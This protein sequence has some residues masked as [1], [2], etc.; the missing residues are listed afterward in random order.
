MGR[1][2]QELVRLEEHARQFIARQ[3]G[4]VGELFA[5]EDEVRLEDFLSTIKQADG[6]QLIVSMSDKR[7]IKDKHNREKGL[8]R[9]Q[10]HIQSGKN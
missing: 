3:E 8:E 7:A 10:K 9:L 2:E 5:N 6:T 1:T 4:F